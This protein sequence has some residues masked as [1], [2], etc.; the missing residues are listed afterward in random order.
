M[1]NDWGRVAANYAFARLV[2]V[3]RM[4]TDVDTPYYNNYALERFKKI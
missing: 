4:I 1:D 3:N 2:Y